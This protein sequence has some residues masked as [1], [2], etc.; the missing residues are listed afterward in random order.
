M[1]TAETYGR[2]DRVERLRAAARDAAE[3]RSLANRP[4]VVALRIERIERRVDM[5]LWTGI[6]LGLLFTMV[7]VLPG[8]A[9]GIDHVVAAIDEHLATDASA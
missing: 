1:T 6:G 4:D 5:L 8:S 9:A 3:I 2:T 7:N